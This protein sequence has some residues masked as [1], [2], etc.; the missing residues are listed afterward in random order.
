M[1]Y[2]KMRLFVFGREGCRQICDAGQDNDGHAS[3]NTS[4]H[5]GL[6]TVPKD[7][8]SDIPLSRPFIL[9][10]LLKRFDLL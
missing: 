6:K 4:I 1:H 8:S 3:A 10:N 9:A 7:A 5:R 2:V